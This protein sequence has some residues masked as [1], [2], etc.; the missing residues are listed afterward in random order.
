MKTL[1]RLLFALVLVICNIAAPAFAG[2]TDPLFVNLTTD[3]THRATWRFHSGK[4][5]LSAGTP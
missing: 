2:N 5:S 3:D 1:S 4:T